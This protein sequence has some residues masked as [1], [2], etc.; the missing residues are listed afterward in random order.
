MLG[1]QQWIADVVAVYLLISV[2][3]DFD[4][5]HRQPTFPRENYHH[6]RRIPRNKALWTSATENSHWTFPGDKFPQ[7][8]ADHHSPWAAC[9]SGPPC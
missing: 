7:I 5:C 6:P 2:Y 9:F 3:G 4:I 1:G 8:S